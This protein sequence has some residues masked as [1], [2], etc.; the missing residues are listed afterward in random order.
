MT[1]KIEETDHICPPECIP[2]LERAVEI[3]SNP[4]RRITGALRKEKPVRVRPMSTFYENRYC[5]LGV[6]N[7]AAH[8]VAGMPIMG[9]EDDISDLAERLIGLDSDQVPHIN[10]D[11]RDSSEFEWRGSGRSKLF[12]R[13]KFVLQ[14][15]KRKA[16]TEGMDCAPDATSPL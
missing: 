15:S 13:M 9:S 1:D 12:K 14:Q 2:I 4:R 11:E 16:K 8:E 3:W 7:Q 5:A 10:D 6:L